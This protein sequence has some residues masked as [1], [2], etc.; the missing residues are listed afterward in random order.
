[1]KYICAYQISKEVLKK[2]G[3]PL[4][5]KILP[6]DDPV[7]RRDVVEQQQQEEEEDTVKGSHNNSHARPSLSG[8]IVRSSPSVAQVPRFIPL[9]KPLRGVEEVKELLPDERT[10]QN[11][12]RSHQLQYIIMERFFGDWKMLLGELQVLLFCHIKFIS[13]PATTT[14]TFH[15]ISVYS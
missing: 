4:G 6:G 10:R 1:M 8:S 13:S 5:N 11:M 7:E 2:C 3:M 9:C 15:P 12:D 14:Y